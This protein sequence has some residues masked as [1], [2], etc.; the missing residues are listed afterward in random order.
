MEPA[1]GRLT[2]GMSLWTLTLGGLSYGPRVRT[3]GDR[4]RIHA[5]LPSRILSL[6]GYDHEVIL[7]RSLR[8]ITVLEK[9][10]WRRTATLLRFQ[11]VDHI[12]YEYRALPTGFT[13]VW[14][15]ADAFETFEIHL[16]LRDGRRVLVA[17]YH[18]EGAAETGLAGVLLDDSIIDVSG[19]QEEHA[20]AL[21][22]LLA[23]TLGVGV[24]S[25]VPPIR[26]ALG[27]LHACT[28]CRRPSPPRR[29]KCQYC[30][31]A[32]AP[33]GQTSGS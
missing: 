27:R 4:I 20:Y 24:G 6:G 22:R 3:E 17:R 25:R 23:T 16:V 7:D 10:F 32:V 11:D 15:A 21:V 26:D 29:K 33:T 9:R 1:H 12:D 2:G 8:R 13:S 28:G 31:A 30:G 19:D 5:R 18:G 14:Q